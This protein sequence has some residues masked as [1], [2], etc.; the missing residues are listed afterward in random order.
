V[1]LGIFPF[2]PSPVKYVIAGGKSTPLST[3]RFIG[4]AIADVATITRF[5]FPRQS[6]IA[7]NPD[8]PELSIED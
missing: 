5:H 4:F 1:I 6:V 3:F 8:K 2:L 7:P